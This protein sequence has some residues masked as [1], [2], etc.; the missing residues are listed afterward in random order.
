M[1]STG[2]DE[3]LTWLPLAAI[4]R[5]VGASDPNREEPEEP[6]SFGVGIALTT[7]PSTTRGLLDEFCFALGEATGL[8]IVPAGAWHYQH[9]LQE[10]TEGRMHLVWLPPI[11]ALRATVEGRLVPV[12]LP[13][14]GGV[15]TYR[16]A[17]FS[18]AGSPFVTIDDL[19]GARAAWVHGQSATGYLIIRAQL[20]AQGVN[21]KSAFSSDMFL[22]SH[23][24][25]AQAVEDGDADV[26]ATYIYPAV[27]SGGVRKS[28]AGWGHRAMQLIARS[29]PIPSDVVAADHRVP[30]DVVERVRAA[31]VGAE[32][33]ALCKAAKALLAADAF[34]APSAEVLGPLQDL[35]GGLKGATGVHS[36]FPPPLA[37]SLPPPPLGRSH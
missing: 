2:A 34:V 4:V 18:R 14:R 12:A 8:P 33:P 10:L 6:P 17:L 16:A 35:L 30:A 29:G 37:P 1:P 27:E 15:S 5:V 7:D 22:G 26:G 20:E 23:D 28:R 19:R 36:L 13:V 31:L 21:L 9:L 3:H 11:L 24:A 25:V 32:H